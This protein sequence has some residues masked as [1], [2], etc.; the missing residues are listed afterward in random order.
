MYTFEDNWRTGMVYAMTNAYE[1][2]EVIA[3]RR[4][5]YGTLTPIDAYATGGGGTGTMK[6]SSATPQNGIDPLTSQGS[7]TFS[8]DGQFLFA[9]NAGSG[10]ISSF[11]VAGDGRL[12]LIDVKPSGGA[13]P[14]SLAIFG[15]LL[16]VSNVGNAANNFASNITGFYLAN[17]GH[18]TRITGSKRPLST[19]NAQPVCVAFSPGGWFLVVSELTTNRLSVFRVNKNGTVTGSII[20][21]SSGG[22]F[23]SKFLSTGLLLV[24]EVMTNALSSYTV[25][26]Q[27]TLNVISGS[28]P[29]GQML[30]CW[31]ATTPD[32]R[33]AYTSNTGSGTITLYSI[34]HN[35]T[36]AARGSINSTPAGAPV[37]APIDSGIS[38][39]GH[40]FYVL[41]GN[42]GSISVFRIM[43]D[44][45]LIRL[46]V[47]KG[48][49][50]PELGAQGLAVR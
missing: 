16:Y 13:Q 3:F 9:V 20:H 1:R 39:D 42:Q 7:L 28:V 35:G 14:N 37:G 46:Q 41:N 26:A 5:I 47:I 36:L 22:P 15:N 33:F 29:N 11:W 4:D 6:V 45:R 8:P 24:A 17:D 18:L 30:T 12:T 40:N 48:N 31:I 21:E 44:G 10:S 38:N 2:N 19:P 43:H 32:E 34:N 49:G 50:L 25:T 27:G 23:G